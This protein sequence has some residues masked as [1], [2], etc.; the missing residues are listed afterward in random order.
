[1]SKGGKE[2]EQKIIQIMILSLKRNIT[3]ETLSCSLCIN[4]KEKREKVLNTL[5]AGDSETAY[6]PV[7]IYTSLTLLCSCMF[8]AMISLP[9]SA[10]FPPYDIVLQIEKS[11]LGKISKII[12]S[13][14]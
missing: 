3:A 13:V 14:L 12:S 2:G 11:A 1:M 6:V 10:C 4:L 9:L 7:M 8:F 5:N